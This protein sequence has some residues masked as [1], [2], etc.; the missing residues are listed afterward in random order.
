MNA[1]ISAQG[2]PQSTGTN[3]GMLPSDDNKVG[4]Y[5]LFLLVHEVSYVASR[6]VNLNI[7]LKQQDTDDFSHELNSRTT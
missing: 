1:L 5:H 4:K 7:Y 3:I 2:M 6:V